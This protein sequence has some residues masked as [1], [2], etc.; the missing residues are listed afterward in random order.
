M[1]YHNSLQKAILNDYVGTSSRVIKSTR[2]EGGHVYGAK[3]TVDETRDRGIF[4]INATFT[5]ESQNDDG[6]YEVIQTQG[7][8]YV[9]YDA[10]TNLILKD[11]YLLGY[12]N[13]WFDGY[14]SEKVGLVF[15]DNIPKIRQRSNVNTKSESSHTDFAEETF[16][17]HR[18]NVILKNGKRCKRDSN[19]VNRSD[20]GHG[21]K[22]SYNG[23]NFNM[24]EYWQLPNLS[25]EWVD[26][27]RLHFNMAVSGKK[28]VIW[29][30]R[31]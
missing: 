27:C 3:L 7:A 28:F 31:A 9:V 1:L 29:Q 25:G 21:V 18:C 2:S 24:E 19:T 5:R 12:E 6:D 20:I 26:V 17:S 15:D 30:D 11:A 4:V 13:S 10:N 14:F 22:N 16:T 23:R 8:N